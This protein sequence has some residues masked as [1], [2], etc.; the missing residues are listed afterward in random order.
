VRLKM[1][2][3]WRGVGWALISSAAFWALG[4][5]AL[6]SVASALRVLAEALASA[7]ASRTK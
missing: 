7:W 5:E 4:E 1:R 6:A 3:T 2:G